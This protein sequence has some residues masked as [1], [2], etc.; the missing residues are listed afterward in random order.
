MG[1]E[2]RAMGRWAVL[3]NVAQW[4]G[5]ERKKGVGLVWARP[6]GGGRRMREGAWRSVAAP[7]HRAWVAP[8]LREQGRAAAMG[9]A[10][11]RA[12]VADEQDQG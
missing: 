6:R 5:A 1:A 4:R 3:L 8:L 9:D 11:M 12:S 7:D 2:R 10:E